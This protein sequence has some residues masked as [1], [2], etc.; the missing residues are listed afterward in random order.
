MWILFEIE[1]IIFF[2]KSCKTLA[3]I[4]KMSDIQKGGMETLNKSGKYVQ[5]IILA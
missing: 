1:P 5:Y 3:L 2:W 4:S